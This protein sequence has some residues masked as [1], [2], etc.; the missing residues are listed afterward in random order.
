MRHLLVLFAIFTLSTGAWADPT[1][2]PFP[3]SVGGQ[4]A[5]M[6]EQSTNIAYIANPVSSGAAMA[7]KDVKGQIIVNIFPGDDKGNA[8]PGAQPFILLFDAGSTKNLSDN[9]QGKSLPAGWY[10]ANV[11]GGGNTSRIAFQVK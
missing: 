7:V 6:T 5:A 1:A 2:L 4:Q 8:K 9:M 10:L 11:V 3:V